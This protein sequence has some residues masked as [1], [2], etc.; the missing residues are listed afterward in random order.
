TSLTPDVAD[1]ADLL[2]QLG[3]A[4]ADLRLAAG[5]LGDRQA[6]AVIALLGQVADGLDAVDARLRGTAGLACLL[7]Q[8]GLA[9]ADGLAAPLDEVG[10][11][12]MAMESDLD[13]GLVAVTPEEVEALSAALLRVKDGWWALRRDRLGLARSVADLAPAGLAVGPDTPA[14]LDGLWSIQVAL[15]SLDRLEVRGR[16]SAGVHVLIADH[17]LDLG[18]PDLQALLGARVTDPLFTS[19]AVRTPDGCLSLVY[20]AAAEIGE[21]GDN[22]RALR[23]AIRSDPLLALALA[24]PGACTTVLG[25][26]RWA[27]VG[28]ISQANAHPLNSDE[29]GITGPYVTAAL[30]G[31]IDNYGELRLSEALSLPA[32]MTTDAKVI[33]TLVSRR[34][35]DH[36]GMDGAF[37]ST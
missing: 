11:V 7:A 15:S 31:D 21:L 22:V 30:N 14:A 17:G 6:G 2:A 5:Q 20:K 13:E 3:D 19:L 18:H 23:L 37:T 28:I 12:A 9:T 36:P 8:P 4:L 16:D 33:P 26:T 1:P 34:L 29:D 10:Q 27:S 32:E 35:S 25:H 24:Q